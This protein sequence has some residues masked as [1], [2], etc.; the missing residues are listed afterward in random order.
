VRT[1]A[2]PETEQEWVEHWRYDELVRAGYDVEAAEAIA[3]CADVDLHQA[4]EMIH[5]GCGQKLALE[6]LL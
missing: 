4:V 6:I 2:D 5:E 1:S 3:V